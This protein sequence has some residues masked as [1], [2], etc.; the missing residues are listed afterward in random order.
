[1][2]QSTSRLPPIAYATS[3]E[4]PEPNEAQTTGELI[5]TLKKINTTTFKD[6]KHG[7]RPVH[8]K[9]H[10]LLCGELIVLDN[11]PPELAQGLFAKPQRLPVVMR[12]STVPGDLL[13]D[14][15]STPRGLAIKVIG[16]GGDRVEGSE[17]DVTQD[18]VMVNGPAFGA[19]DAAHFLKSLKLVASTTDKGESLKVAFSAIARGT[20]KVVEAL[21]G[22]SGT[23]L[24]MGGQ[25]ETHVLGDSFYTQVPLLHGPYIAKFSVVPVS[26]E[27]TALTGKTVDLTGRANGLREEVVKF[28]KAH[29]AVWEVR[30]QLC[31]DLAQMPIE[32]ASVVW[33][34]SLSPYVAVARITVDPQTAW[35]QQRA[36]AIDDQMSFS[37]WHALAAHRPLG[38]VMRVRKSIYDVM[39]SVRA[40][41]NGVHIEEPKSMP[42]I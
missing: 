20:E 1:M 19:P 34:E 40:A 2:S 41:Q 39:S 27:L 31:R 25:P 4:Q 10:G 35:S 14:K 36:A 24:A 42:T 7:L 8:A 6:E 18:F 23:L 17:G 37:P 26:S 3:M 11:L 22:K 16:V 38:S 12:F 13:D 15:V 32:N 29:S 21:G 9:S 5:D 28:F 33:P 30:V